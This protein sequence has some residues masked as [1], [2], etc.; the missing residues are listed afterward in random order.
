L[1]GSAGRNQVRPKGNA[2]DCRRSASGAALIGEVTAKSQFEN[3]SRQWRAMAAN[4]ETMA[5]SRRVLSG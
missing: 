1:F 2:S 4:A 5:D 3:M